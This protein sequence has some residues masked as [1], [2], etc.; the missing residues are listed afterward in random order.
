MKFC[1]NSGRWVF[2]F[3]LISYADGCKS[4]RYSGKTRSVGSIEDKAVTSER[5][6]DGGDVAG[7]GTRNLG[8]EG[9][10]TG[11]DSSLDGLVLST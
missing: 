7:P 8:R 10:I 4:I 11:P 6:K 2:F 3:F 1:W 9:G 5:G